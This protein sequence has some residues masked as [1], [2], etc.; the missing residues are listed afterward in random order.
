MFSIAWSLALGIITTQLIS[1]QP[2]KPFPREALKLYQQALALAESDTP[3]LALPVLEQLCQAHPASP[4]AAV[5]ALRVAEFQL[6]SGE[7]TDAL[8]S[9]LSILGGS[10]ELPLQDVQRIDAAFELRLRQLL[11][12]LIAVEAGNKHLELLQIWLQDAPTSVSSSSIIPN[13]SDATSRTPTSTLELM[14]AIVV[15]QLSFAHARAGRFRQAIELLEHSNIVLTHDQQKSIDWEM[16]LAL[17]QSKP[18]KED[19][20]WMAAKLKASEKP[21]DRPSRQQIALRL[22]LGEAQRQQGD[23]SSAIETFA[24]LAQQLQSHASKNL[25]NFSSPG[26]QPDSIGPTDLLEWRATACL[27]QAELLLQTGQVLSAWQVSNALLNEHPQYTNAN[28]LRFLI[29][30]CQ[31]A[32]VEFDNAKQA[33][34]WLADP[35][36]TSRETEIAQA[37]WMLGEI[38]LLQRNYRQALQNYL[39][40]LELQTP[41]AWHPRAIFQAGKCHEMLGSPLDALAAYQSI[42]NQYPQSEVAAAAINRIQQLTNSTTSKSSQATNPTSTTETISR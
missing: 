31:I 1:T 8:R 12:H 13:T 17:L 10:Y 16:P 3:H 4:L 27:R 21:I 37:R 33:L 20:A 24:G 40:V 7:S 36:N 30:R 38:D 9:L 2:P 22:A 28:Q 18:S 19:V 6:A 42:A 26:L 35:S 23:L 34:H 29:V 15:D 14:R 11:T 39:S 25:I 32:Q 41:S 5:S